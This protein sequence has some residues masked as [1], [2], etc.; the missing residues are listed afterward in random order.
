[1]LGKMID[2]QYGHPTGLLGLF[3]GNR[4]V[5]DHRPENL[6]TISVLQAQPAD[7]ILELGFGGGLAIQELAKVVTQGRV[8][9]IDYSKMMVRAAR[10]RN[11]RLIKQ[12]RVDL[13]WAD[14]ST[15]P[16]E[17]NTFDKA[18]SIHSIYFWPQPLKALAEIL[19]VLKPGGLL[20]LTILPKEKWN[21]NAPD[22][23]VGTP[24]CRPYSANEL[25]D[26]LSTVGFSA[27]QVRS[28]IDPV[29]H[30]NFSVIG[31]K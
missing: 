25:I 21:I 15:L 27:T 18:F 11:A 1:M 2:K 19:R 5:Q 30:S 17:D 9:G 7:Q 23:P 24:D 6:W 28:G 29:H 12:G 4:M 3:I 22:L 14:A 10:W 31:V 13:R 26:M 16:F 20:V 8:A